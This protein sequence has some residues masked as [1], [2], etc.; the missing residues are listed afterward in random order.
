MGYSINGKY[1]SKSMHNLSRRYSGADGVKYLVIHYVGAGTPKK[2]NAKANCIFFNRANRNA[3]AD[4][5]IDNGG[6]Y[7]YN[8]NCSKWYSWHCGDGHGKYGITNA[9]S[10]GIEVCING[11]KPY[12]GAEKR[13]LR[14]LVRLL[15]KRYGIDKKH[16]VRHYDA[17]RKECPYYYTPAGKGG[18]KAWAA[19]REY[20]TRK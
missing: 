3:S 18:N 10:I 16:V 11:N 4:F 17:S 15:M 19:L 13:R 12:T 1:K 20:I 9:N 14:W 6:I 8:P 2:G 7:R 5:F